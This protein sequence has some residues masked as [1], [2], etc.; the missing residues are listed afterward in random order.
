MESRKIVPMTLMCRV[1][2]E[3]QI[4]G[5]SGRRGWDDVRE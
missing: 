4:F 2:K 5:H 3:T 1:A